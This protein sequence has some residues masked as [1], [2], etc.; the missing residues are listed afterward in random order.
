MAEKGIASPRISANG[1]NGVVFNTSSKGKDKH[2]LQTDRPL[3][4]VKEPHKKLRVAFSNYILS[5]FQAGRMTRVSTSS[6]CPFVAR[7]KQRNAMWSCGRHR[8]PFTGQTVE[9]L[10]MNRAFAV[11]YY[12]D[13]TEDLWRELSEAGQESIFKSIDAY[14]GRPDLGVFISASI[15]DDPVRE[16]WLKVQ[17]RMDSQTAEILSANERRRM[18]LYRG[19]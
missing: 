16:V 9:F 11:D 10:T 7:S 2:F 12:K 4:F 19:L 8:D 18:S 1:G 6:V 17:E 14:L 15:A 13:E 3:V 5:R